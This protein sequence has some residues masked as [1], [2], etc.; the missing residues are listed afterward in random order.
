[1]ITDS[2]GAIENALT[3]SGCLPDFTIAIL[4]GLVLDMNTILK[5][6][7]ECYNSDAQ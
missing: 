7:W 3:L 2:Y 6:F 1:M 4:V 5:T